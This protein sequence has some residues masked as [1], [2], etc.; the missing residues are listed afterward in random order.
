MRAWPA[1]TTVA[2]G[3]SN[4]S[5][6]SMARR[7]RSSVT[8]PIAVLSASTAAIA[9]DSMRSPSASATSAAA[10][11]RKTTTLVSW[12]TKTRSA[13]TGFVRPVDLDRLP[14]VVAPPRRH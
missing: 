4:P 8:N 11:S 13:D 6:A 3:T 9:A 7:A 1:R 2:R 10:A 12:L 5:N 14:R